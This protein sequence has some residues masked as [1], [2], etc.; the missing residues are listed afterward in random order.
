[1]QPR[2]ITLKYLLDGAFFR[3]A[4]TIWGDREAP[5]V[6]CVHGLT[7]QGRDFDALAQVLAEQFYVVCPDLPGRGNSEWL[8]APALYQPLVYA[9]ALSHLL[10]LI[11]RPVRWV[12]T[13]LGGICG[14]I[15]A[16][17]PKNPIERMVLNDIGPFIPREALA[18]IAAYIGDVPDFA[19]EAAL[20]SYLRRV[21]APFGALTDAQWAEMA[22]H[23]ARALPDGGVALHYDPALTLPM[24]TAAPQDIDMGPFWDKIEIP[25]LAI[26]GA[27]SD[28]LLPETLD[29]MAAKAEVHVVENA[30]HAPALMDTPTIEIIRKFLIK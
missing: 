1:M 25:I 9:L 22:R 2:Q 3:M 29:R 13:S 10:A 27:R 16:A 18:R 17:A 15:L 23:S 12:G 28:L 11:D 21:H 14:M 30:G 8:P 6:I 20:E 7:R 19:D 4:C 5:P 24:R 26:R